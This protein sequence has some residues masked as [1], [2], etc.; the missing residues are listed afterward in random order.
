MKT[1]K[2]LFQ[3]YPASVRKKLLELRT[4]ILKVAKD[5]ESVGPIEENLRWGQPSYLTSS[6]KSGTTIRIDQ[7]KGRKDQYAMYFHCQ[8][9]LVSDFKKMFGDNLVYEGQRAIIFSV[10]KSLPKKV[11]RQCIEM[12]LTYHQR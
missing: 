10:K 4:L 11:I 5:L 2:D 3:H 8:T 12:A 7:Y 9:D 1:N 6:S